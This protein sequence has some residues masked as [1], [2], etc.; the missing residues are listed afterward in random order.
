MGLV[1]KEL[2]NKTVTI[3]GSSPTSNIQGRGE[4]VSVPS[5]VQDSNRPSKLIEFDRIVWIY[6][7]GL[8][9]HKAYIITT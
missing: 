6:F 2:L 1:A 3:S 9:E 5:S 8:T 4:R 7:G